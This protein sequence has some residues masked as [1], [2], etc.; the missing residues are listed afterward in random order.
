[1]DACSCAVNALYYIIPHIILQ[2]FPRRENRGRRGGEPQKAKKARNSERPE[3]L[4][5]P[6]AYMKTLFARNDDAVHGDV[7]E[8]G[9]AV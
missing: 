4:S 9:A 7:R 5:L 1:M 2:Y 6:R 3:R 8:D